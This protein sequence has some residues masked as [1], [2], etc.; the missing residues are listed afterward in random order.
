MALLLPVEPLVDQLEVVLEVE[1]GEDEGHFEFGE[2]IAQGESEKGE[3]V[4]QTACVGCDL[5]RKKDC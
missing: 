2:A 1:L 4:K 5:N 3:N